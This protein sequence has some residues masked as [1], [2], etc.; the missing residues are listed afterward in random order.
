MQVVIGDNE[1]ELP[2]ALFNVNANETESSFVYARNRRE[3]A[4]SPIDL[5]RWLAAGSPNV[6]SYT[7]ALG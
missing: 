3:W 4:E 5:N 7:K 1:D 2:L 6:Y